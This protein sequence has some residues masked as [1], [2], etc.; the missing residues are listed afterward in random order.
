MVKE[1]N[2]KKRIFQGIGLAA[3]AAGIWSGN[4]IVARA[5]HQQIPPISLGFFRWLTATIII[6][7]FA[8]QSFVKEWPL[9]KKNFM[10]FFFTALTGITLFN[11]L[12]YVAAHYSSAINMAIIGTSSSPIMAS[13]LAAVFLKEKLTLQ[14]MAGMAIC[15]AGILL[16]VSKASWQVLRHFQFSAGDV[17]VLAG[18]F[19]FA[20]YNVLV[21]KKPTGISAIN[22]LLI[23]FSIGTCLLL[24]LYIAE[25]KQ[26]IHLTPLH[27]IKWSSH[28][29]LNI[30]YL[31]LG[32]SV[33]SFLCWN[34]AIDR[35]GAAKTA[36]FG[37]LIPIFSSIEAV[38]LLGEQITT[39]N[40]IS[41]FLVLSGLVLATFPGSRPLSKS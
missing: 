39:I 30:A 14:K 23:V 16:L 11:T 18:A 1:V 37:N 12:V 4:F 2:N 10:Y 24:P 7:P 22:F 19:M 36:L 38:W 17:W 3:L 21:R 31:G 13:I 27:E 15:I 33:I 5:V 32:T 28:L 40:Y 20:I 25:A 6:L 41:G 26:V 34:A 29:L 35:L 8:A 9:M